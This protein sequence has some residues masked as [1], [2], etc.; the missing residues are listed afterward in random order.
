[1]PALLKSVRFTPEDLRLL[2]HFAQKLGL[3]QTDVIRRG[4]RALA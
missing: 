3:S 1:V 4:L 2:E